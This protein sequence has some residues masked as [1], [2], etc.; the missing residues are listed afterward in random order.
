MR[1][2]GASWGTRCPPLWRSG[3]SP[4]GIAEWSRQIVRQQPHI[5]VGRHI[6]MPESLQVIMGPSIQAQGPIRH[7]YDSPGL[8]LHRNGGNQEPLSRPFGWLSTV[9]MLLAAGFKNR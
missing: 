2:D 7:P 1:D 6:L 8:I 4:Y 5:E 3:Q 9:I